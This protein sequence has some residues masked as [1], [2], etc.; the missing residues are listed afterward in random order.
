[1]SS[2][3]QSPW[4]VLRSRALLALPLATAL[5]ALAACSPPPSSPPSTTTTTTTSTTTAAPD[6]SGPDVVGEPCPVGAGVTV[7][8]DFTELD[9]TVRIGC[10]PGAPA[11]G[12][13]ALAAAGFT[14]TDESGP[15]TACT[16]DGLPTEGYPFCWL[17]GGFWGY[18]KSPDRETAW[19]F[20]MVGP[21]TGPLVEGSVEGWAWA[22]GF[23]GAAPRVSIAELGS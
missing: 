6:P 2:F 22:A 13:A 11:D 5:V 3:R 17:T 20:A 14:V 21:G 4:G 7:V 12:Y 19:D 1:M 18:W 10:A 9:D 8:V 15:G 16:I 23:S